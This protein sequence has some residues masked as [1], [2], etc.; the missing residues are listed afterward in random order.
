MFRNLFL[1]VDGVKTDATA[2]GDLSCAFYVSS[3]LKMFGCIK[4]L[5]ATVSGT[6]KDLVESG[7]TEVRQPVVGSVIVWGESENSSGHKHIGFY[8]GEDQAV[9]NNSRKKTPELSDWRFGGDRNVEL[10]LC[11]EDF[12]NK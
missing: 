1:D 5:H 3:V 8:L 12:L 7:W 9:S 10:I 11:K 2:D 6:V 4:T